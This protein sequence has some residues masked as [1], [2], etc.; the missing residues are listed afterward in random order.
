MYLF[1]Y[2]FI[3]LSVVC[4]YLSGSNKEREVMREEKSLRSGVCA[5]FLH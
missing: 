1:M 2:L 3:R 4:L 5:G